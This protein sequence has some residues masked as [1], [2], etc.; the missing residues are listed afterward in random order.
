MPSAGSWSPKGKQLVVGKADG[1]LVQLKPQLTEVK[2][3]PP[4][5][6]PNRPGSYIAKAI[7]WSASTVFFVSHWYDS[8]SLLV[9][10]TLQVSFDNSRIN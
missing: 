2:T 1:S 4:P 10:T 3:I 9:V 7:Y 5:V 6:L 8:T